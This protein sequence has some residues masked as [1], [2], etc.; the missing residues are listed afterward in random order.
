MSNRDDTL[1]VYPDAGVIFHET[2]PNSE[3]AD[4]ETTPAVP[5]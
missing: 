4:T 1:H 3:N 5:E 2:A